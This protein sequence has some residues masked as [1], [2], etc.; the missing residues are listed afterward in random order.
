MRVPPGLVGMTRRRLT[1]RQTGAADVR[2]S[3]HAATVMGGVRHVSAANRALRR[4][5]KLP[6]G[7]VAEIP[8]FIAIR[9]AAVQFGWLYHLRHALRYHGGRVMNNG[10][11]LLQ[12]GQCEYRC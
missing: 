5:V 2:A 9:W 3:D 10:L 12:A 6:D 8:S 11:L 4:R 7:D 1:S